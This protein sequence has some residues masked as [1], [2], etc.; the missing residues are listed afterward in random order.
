MDPG[1]TELTDL[2]QRFSRIIGSPVGYIVA[3]GPPNLDDLI[4]GTAT[5]FWDSCYLFRLETELLGYTDSEFPQLFL[6]VCGR[7]AFSSPCDRT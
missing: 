1:E 7:A 3:D 4:R 6:E 2:R 5:F